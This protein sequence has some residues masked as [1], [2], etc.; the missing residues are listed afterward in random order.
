MKKTPLRRVNPKRA[1]ANREY[2]KIRAVYLRENPE[3]GWCCNKA[4]EIHHLCSGGSRAK[5]LVNSDTWLGLCGQCHEEL[6]AAP[7][8]SQVYVKVRQVIATINRL[9]GRAENAITLEDLV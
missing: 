5:S 1:K 3:C 9:R 8:V 6:Q 4:S 2:A 7:I